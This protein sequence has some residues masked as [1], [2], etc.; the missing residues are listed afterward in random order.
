MQRPVEAPAI[1][2]LTATRTPGQTSAL[3][4]GRI[5]VHGASSE[6]VDLVAEW[7][8]APAAGPPETAPRH[9]HVLEHPVHVSYDLP[10]G[11]TVPLDA[12]RYDEGAGEVVLTT[13]ASP[14]APALDGRIQPTPTPRHEFGDTRHRRVRYRAVA[15]SRFREYLPEALTADPAN[16]TRQ[17]EPFTVEVPSCARPQAPQVVQVLPTFAWR[18]GPVGTGVVSTRRGGGLRVYL[19]PPWFTSGEGE[20]LGMVLWPGGNFSPDQP[21]V[22]RWGRD[23]IWPGDGLPGSAPLRQD[24]INPVATAV[25][26]R[27]ADHGS[28]IVAVAGY[29]VTWDA[30]RG[31]WSCD[32][33]LRMPN[34]YTPFVRLALVRWQ[35]SSLPDLEFSPVVLAEFAQ[36]APD[37]ALTVVRVAAGLPTDFEPG[38]PA[39]QPLSVRLQLDGPGP[40][41]RVDVSV[42]R[43]LPGTAN[44]V[45]WVDAT[46]AGIDGTQ[47]TP[48]ADSSARWVGRVSF[49][50]ANADRFRI[51][52]RESEVFPDG[53]L[54]VL[55]VE[56]LEI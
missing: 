15:T 27:L 48:P 52:V 42:Q 49:P 32:V 31:L 45:G 14:A 10:P 41:T 50:D 54:R 30:D 1:S 53:Q 43:R 36:P 47:T 22:T 12:V 56:T 33:G 4:T 51:V 35:P 21:F 7:D 2:S 44:E 25:D 11:V 26:V 19:Q 29:P 28:P 34:A 9:A 20:L 40:P 13:L 23:P 6:R 55:F 3:L 5:R 18:R 39:P 38:D 16:V 37:R 17:S 8:E 24:A 46:D